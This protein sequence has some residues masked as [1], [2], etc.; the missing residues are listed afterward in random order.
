MCG[1]PNVAILHRIQDEV[2][3]VLDGLRAVLAVLL[4]ANGAER[5]PVRRER[6]GSLRV[7]RGPP[8]AGHEQADRGR[9]RG[10]VCNCGVV[11][12]R[13]SRGTAGAFALKKVRSPGC[14]E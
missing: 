13:E 1:E 3:A 7:T 8:T 11:H 14:T 5:A 9:R 4:W 2:S 12:D 6:R 10:E